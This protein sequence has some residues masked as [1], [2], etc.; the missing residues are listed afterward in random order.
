MELKKNKVKFED[1]GN[2]SYKDAW[3]YQTKLHEALI[4]R[5]KTDQNEPPVHSLLFVEHPHVYTLGKSGS[6]D[7]LLVDEE[8][9]EKR[10]I[11][12]FKIN[13]GGDIT[14]HGPGQIVVYPIFDL[15]HFK[16]DVRWYVET[17][18]EAVIRT[19]AEYGVKA[20]RMEKHTGVWVA[21]EPG[22]LERKV[23]ALGVHLSRWVS[24]HGIAFNVNTDLDLF[25]MIVPCGI[26]DA[27]KTVS[28]LSRELGQELDYDEVKAK[29]KNNLA[30]LFNLEFV[31]E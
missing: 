25:K 2:M 24:L 4:E 20:K 30:D 6:M 5:K 22:Q 1:L 31:K 18:E 8:Q 21:T 23:C 9:R 17:L 28:S 10:G 7:H 13:R 19:M 11:D 15:D 12:F 26:A 29:L 27:N 14:Y 16:N 3:A